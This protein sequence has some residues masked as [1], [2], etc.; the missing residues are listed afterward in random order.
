VTLEVAIW[1]LVRRLGAMRVGEQLKKLVGIST[2]LDI[3]FGTK[4]SFSEKE[5][6]RQLGSYL[7]ELQD[8]GCAD[9]LYPTE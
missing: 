2:T 9:L 3:L 8:A 6:L 7:R 1:L 5:V 4:E